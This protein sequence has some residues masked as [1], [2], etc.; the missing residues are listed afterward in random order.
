MS[1]GKLVVQ[2]PIE[3]LGREAIAGGKFQIEVQASPITDKLLEALR[4]INGII[5]ITQ[6]NEVLLITCEKDLRSQ[7]SRTIVEQDSMLTGIK[8]EEFGLEEIYL[9][10]FKEA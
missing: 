6:D 2:G 3:L 1:K 8:I 9:K 5:N 7:I 4:K 10:Y